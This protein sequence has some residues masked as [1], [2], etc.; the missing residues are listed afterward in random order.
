MKE[1]VRFQKLLESDN[2]I[3]K[4]GL[5]LPKLFNITNLIGELSSREH[6]SFC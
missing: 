6:C 3:V 4:V 2:A 5:E 1:L